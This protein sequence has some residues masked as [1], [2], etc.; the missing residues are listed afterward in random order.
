MESAAQSVE[1][2]VTNW[3]TELAGKE[4][5]GQFAKSSK[6]MVSSVEFSMVNLVTSLFCTDS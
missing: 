4:R 2:S 5:D 1:S 6:W 3:T